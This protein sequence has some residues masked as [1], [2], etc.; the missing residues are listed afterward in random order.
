VEA[1][2]LHGFASSPG[3]SKASFLAERFGAHSVPLHAPDL[4]LPDFSTLTVTRM[5]DQLDRII[6]ARPS[7]PVV[8]VGSSLGGF[9]ALH[10]ADR[11]AGRL[12]DRH[13]VSHLVLLAPAVDFGQMRDPLV[14]PGNIE[15]WRNTDRWELFHEGY[16][17]TV[18]VRF[19][20]WEDAGR[21]DS[22]AVT[23][24]VPTL[25][26]HGTGDTVVDLRSVQRFA[27]GRP[28]VTLRLLEGADHRLQGRLD[29]AWE[30]MAHFL[31]LETRRL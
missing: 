25:V 3:S 28:N 17:R 4:N 15:A 12:D 19:E 18:P 7:G 13:P 22:L 1:F 14:V 29:T 10:A 2:Y 20:L 11:R 24:K 9:V 8:L 26:I 6:D 30:E 27:D 16:G 31:A 23:P 21:Y 5:I